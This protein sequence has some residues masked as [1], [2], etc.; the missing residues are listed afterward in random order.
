MD[1]IPLRYGAQVDDLL[2]GLDA[3]QLQAVTSPSAPLA[4]LAGARSGKTRVLT[5]RNAWHAR[6]RITHPRH[7]LAVTLTR[8]AAGELR[9]RL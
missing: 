2:R 9:T 4:I 5:R 6:E 7:V 1:V 3:S 8:K